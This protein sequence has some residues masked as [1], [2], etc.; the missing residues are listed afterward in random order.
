MENKL[1]IMFFNFLEPDKMV[2]FRIAEK[3]GH[4]GFVEAKLCLNYYFNRTLIEKALKEDEQKAIRIF[5]ELINFTLFSNEHLFN[6]NFFSSEFD[7]GLKGSYEIHLV[8]KDEC[9][10]NAKMYSERLDELPNKLITEIGGSNVYDIDYI[11]PTIYNFLNGKDKEITVP[12]ITLDDVYKNINDKDLVKVGSISINVTKTLENNP[13]FKKLN[14]EGKQF[15]KDVLSAKC[16]I[17]EILNNKCAVNSKYDNL[18]MEM[19]K[20]F[21]PHYKEGSE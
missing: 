4:V 1:R 21:N 19:A 20:K 6:V 12:N 10:I 7:S 9:Y 17:D 14:N 5:S 13:K 15:V 11:R 18:G 3:P 8:M 16:L 2:H